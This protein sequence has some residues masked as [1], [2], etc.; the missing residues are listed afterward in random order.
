MFRIQ[1]QIRIR[2]F[3]GLPDLHPL[4]FVLTR[5]VFSSAEALLLSRPHALELIVEG[6]LGAGLHVTQGEEA[7]P[8]VSVHRPLLGDAVRVT[9]VVHEP[10]RS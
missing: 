3:L 9:A 2:K 5:A 1:S 7:H 8:R 10:V 6:E 4:L